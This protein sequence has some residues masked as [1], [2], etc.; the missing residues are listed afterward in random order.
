MI[1]PGDTIG[2]RYTVI[3]HV[4][5]GGMQEVYRARDGLLEIDVALK[6]PQVGQSAKRFAD[7]A[8]MAARVNNHYVAKTIDYFVDGGV[9]YLVEEFVD[10]E[11]LEQ[12]LERFGFLD[13]HLGARVLHHLAKGVAAS[14]RAGVIHRDLKPSNIMGSSG[15]NLH[16]LK[17][18]DFGIATLAAEVFD[19]ESKAGDF[20]RSTSGTVRGALPYMAPEM[21]FRQPGEILSSAIDIWS[22]G[23]L[24]FKLLTG[25]FPFGVYLDAAVNVK[26]RTRKPWPAFMT[27]HPQFAPLARELQEIVDGCLE[28][29][30]GKR[31]SADELVTRCQALCYLAVEREVGAVE[32]LIQNGYSG[33]IAGDP[34]PIFF[35]ME[36]VYGLS[37][38]NAAK[39]RN[40]CFSSFPG[41]PR[42]RAHPVI[43]LKS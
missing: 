21:M 13:P 7:S 4:G 1:N 17:I 29:E 18:T 10:G 23:A 30:P 24:M 34:E 6:T 43:V 40:V 28:Y 22:V 39:N 37:R 15:V 19:E 27:E 25:D 9:A 5:R 42:R 11:T 20:T 3:E 12:K 16:N 26:N 36:S 14:H 35:S 41:A 32:R 31:P 38:P 8:V 2:E 33:F